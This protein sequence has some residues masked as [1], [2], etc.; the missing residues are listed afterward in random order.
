MCHIPTCCAFH[1]LALPSTCVKFE[2]ALGDAPCWG[3]AMGWHSLHRQPFAMGP[4]AGHLLFGAMHTTYVCARHAA[5]LQMMQM[6]QNH[7]PARHHP[8]RLHPARHHPAH[9]HPAHHHPARHHTAHH[10]PAHHHPARHNPA[11]HQL[12]HHHPD[13][14]LLAHHHHMSYRRPYHHPQC[15]SP[16]L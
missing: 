11:R 7:H 13:R 5:K 8:A 6:M 2:D 1:C 14:L 4:L 9:H 12:D 15:P 16:G 3:P 10:H